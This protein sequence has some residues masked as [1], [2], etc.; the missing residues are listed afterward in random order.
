MRLF[1]FGV[2][3]SATAC[4]K[5]LQEK[6]DL[7][8]GTT[9]TTEKAAYL[10]N[11]EIDSYIFDG[12][13]K[14]PDICCALKNSTHLIISIAP[15]EHG[16]CVLQNYR[17]E[18]IDSSIEWI[19]YL[20][21][22]G[23]YGNHNGDWVDENSECRPTSN[24][25]IYRIKT[26][27]DWSNLARQKN[28]PI[29]ILRLA[30]IYGPGRNTFINLTRGTAKRIIKPGQVFNR[31]YVDD[32]AGAVATSIEQTYNGTLN[33]SDGNPCPPQD[34]VT[35]AAALLGVDPPDEVPFESANISPMARSFYSENKRVSNQKLNTSLGYNL[36]F[37]NYRIALKHLIESDWQQN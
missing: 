7:I 35:F 14:N 34:V 23:V 30:G 28:I 10:K 5:L 17:N 37:P 31:I 27:S 19:G 20:S 11:S 25:S 12:E 6:C 15:S 1:V 4:V 24:R 18:I 33:V 3:Y 32:I 9:R 21:T 22:V 26:E 36:K 8:S 13:T 16:D 2:G 29:S